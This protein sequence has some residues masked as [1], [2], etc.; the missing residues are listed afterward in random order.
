MWW[1]GHNFEKCLP[2]CPILIDSDRLC[3]VKI[4]LS[5]FTLS[6]LCVYLPSTDQDIDEYKRYLN[7]L[8]CTIGAL[9]SKEPVIVAV[10]FNAHLPI[11]GSIQTLKGGY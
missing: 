4:I 6:I 7:E 9:Q 3:G 8:E 1:G 11:L 2:L 5:D 10:D